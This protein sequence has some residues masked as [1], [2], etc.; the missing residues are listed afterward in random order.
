MAGKIHLL[1]RAGP[2]ISYYN[3]GELLGV[4]L[5]LK[6]REE[7]KSTASLRELFQWMNE[8]YARQAI[9]R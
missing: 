4:L 7:S 5:D 3:K 9:L 8:H 2:Q 1:P 6:I